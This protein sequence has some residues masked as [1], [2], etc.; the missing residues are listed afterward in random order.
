[1]RAQ[2]DTTIGAELRDRIASYAKES[3]SK[4]ATLRGQITAALPYRRHNMDYLRAK[5]SGRGKLPPIYKRGQDISDLPEST[6][7]MRQRN[8]RTNRITSDER[9]TKRAM[10]DPIYRRNLLAKI[11]RDETRATA[12][13]ANVDGL[14]AYGNNYAANRD[15]LRHCAQ[16]RE[17][18]TGKAAKKTMPLPADSGN[19]ATQ[20][21]PNLCTMPLDADTARK[22]GAKINMRGIDA[23]LYPCLGDSHGIHAEAESWRRNG[24]WES[25]RAV[26]DN[27][28]QSFAVIGED[29]IL[30][31]RG[32]GRT[33]VLSLPTGYEWA[34][35]ANGLHCRD[36]QRH[37]IDY[38]PTTGELIERDATA[39]IIARLERNRARREEMAAKLAAEKADVE[40]VYVCLADS[41][42]AGNC[43]AGTLAFGERH[44]L[45]PARHYAASELLDIANG[46]SY[47][48][49]L[50]I[51]AATRRHRME[52]DR[53]YADLTDHIAIEQ[54]A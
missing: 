46:D 38:H 33:Y 29:G 21:L 45:N 53:G 50:A 23:A 12:Y 44:N 2:P 40:G 54:A 47:R 15:T 9:A 4:A 1:M 8:L 30:R 49:R 14:E 27:Y 24:R 52:C 39:K 32:N 5:N 16:L 42:N 36:A 28:V 37:A 17:T 7:D 3:G 43:K 31:Y 11:R 41:I 51:A 10:S 34:I 35:D 26:H 25:T 19:R 48:V 6:K 20:I 18:I 13:A 22:I